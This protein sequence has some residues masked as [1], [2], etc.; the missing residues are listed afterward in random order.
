MKSKFALISTLCALFVLIFASREVIASCRYGLTLC[1]ELI[2]PSL[3][4]FF[5]MSVLLGKLGFP[6]WLGASDW[7]N[8]FGQVDYVG[9]VSG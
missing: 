3:F 9:G 4:P 5:V 1:V 8:R 7:S 2:L 6:A